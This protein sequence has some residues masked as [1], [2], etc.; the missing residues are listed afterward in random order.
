MA[1]KRTNRQRSTARRVGAAAPRTADESAVFRHMI[2]SSTVRVI[3][4]DL[5]LNITYMN[6][7]SIETLRKRGIGHACYHTRTGGWR[8]CRGAWPVP[9]I[10]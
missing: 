5:D 3:A 4:A 6:A 9:V 1:R 8:V 7:A 2:V 10:P